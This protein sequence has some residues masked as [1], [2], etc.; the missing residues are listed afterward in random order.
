MWK[1]HPVQAVKDALF[2]HWFE[3]VYYHII[4]YNYHILSMRDA[5]TNTYTIHLFHRDLSKDVQVWPVEH[6][7]KDA[8]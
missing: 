2:L 1:K 4:S 7:A 6:P 3:T 5:Q 8:I